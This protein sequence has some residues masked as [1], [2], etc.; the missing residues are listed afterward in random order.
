MAT[1]NLL[2]RIPYGTRPKIL[3]LGNGMNRAF[4]DGAWGDL[5]D[6]MSCEYF[7][8]NSKYNI[9]GDQLPADGLLSSQHKIRVDAF[10]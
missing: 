9:N 4:G 3:S 7:D 6:Y 2:K 8:K 10:L 5:P 1:N